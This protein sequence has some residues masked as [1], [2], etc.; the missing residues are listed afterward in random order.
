MTRDRR[1]ARPALPRPVAVAR[2]DRGHGC[3]RP[4]AAA[5]AARRHDA[6]VAV[7][8]AGYTGLWTAYSLRA[9]DPSLRVRR[10]RG[11]DRRASAPAGATAAGARRCSRPRRV[12]GPAARPRA[13]LAMRRAMNGTVT[14]SA[15]PRPRRHRRALPQGRHRRRWR[16]PPCSSSG[17]GPPWPRRR[18]GRG[19]G[20]PGAPRCRRGARPL[21]AT[22]VLGATYTPHCAPDP[23]GPA[24][25]GARPGRGASRAPRPRADPRARPS[26][27]GPASAPRPRGPRRHGGPTSC[28]RPRPGPPQLPGSHRD[29][30]P[31]YSLMVATE[32]LPASFWAASG[33]RRR[34]VRRPPP[35][36]D[37]RAADA[38]TTGWSSA[39]AARRTTR[40]ADPAGVRPRDASSRRCGAT[41][42]E[43]FPASADAAFTHAWGG[44]LG[45][46]R[47]WHAGV[48]L[49]P[50]PGWLGGRLRRRRRGHDQPGRPHPRRPRRSAGH[51]SS[52]RLPWVG[53]RSRAGSRNRCAGSASTRACGR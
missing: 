8:G 24:G 38:R 48:G 25:T 14:R 12:P 43:L 26:H 20:R 39:G 34:D 5:A 7:V 40:L 51:A 35:P 47:D 9:A 42:A 32:P 4:R 29:V 21:G 28:G 36:G 30:A 50:A 37:L 53:H 3:R 11:G 23:P 15:A 27:R 22:G 13:A 19:V 10:A 17:P 16:A 52:T 31:V 41:L 18:G 2:H 1:T 46:P 44:P 33:W 45:I 49:D 6:D